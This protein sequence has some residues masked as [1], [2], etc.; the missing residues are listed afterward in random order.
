M[1]THVKAQIKPNFFWM[2]RIPTE[3]S[4]SDYWCA[5][6]H[7]SED[8][9]Q[10]KALLYLVYAF[11]AY[12]ICFEYHPALRFKFQMDVVFSRLETGKADRKVGR[13]A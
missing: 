3:V 12:G 10:M 2:Q 9:K 7:T 1:N 11:S 4:L 13:I 8:V 6:S 5:E